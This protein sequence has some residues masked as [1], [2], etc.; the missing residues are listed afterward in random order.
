MLIEESGYLHTE[1]K[2]SAI[3]Y[4]GVLAVLRLSYEIIAL[5]CLITRQSEASP[6]SFEQLLYYITLL[7][8]L[9]RVNISY[10]HQLAYV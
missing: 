7:L 5:L 1:R 10:L 8:Q 2:H 3:P 9:V 4:I 6:G